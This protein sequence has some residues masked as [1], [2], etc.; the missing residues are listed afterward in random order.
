MNPRLRTISIG[1]LASAVVMMLA[2]WGL[3]SEAAGNLERAGALSAADLE[4]GGP[5]GESIADYRAVL[6]SLN[7]S[8]EIRTEIDAML[9][10]VEGI[11]VALQ[12][13][14]DAARTT[15]DESRAELDM[16]ARTLGGAVGAARSSFDDLG[17]LED[18]LRIAGRLADLIADEL[19]TLDRKLGPTL[20]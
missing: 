16:I 5:G 9:T 6:E 4:D 12:E 20:P 14:S 8:I 1:L 7:E 10:D 3:Q 17:G 13:Q 11:I 2:S 19:E 15:A 18:T